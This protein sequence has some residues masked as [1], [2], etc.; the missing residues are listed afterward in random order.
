M[1][2][3]SLGGLFAQAPNQNSVTQN[4]ETVNY[5]I[6]S[7][8][9]VTIGIEKLLKI[10]DDSTFNLLTKALKQNVKQKFLCY[11]KLCH[12]IG[13]NNIFTINCENVVDLE[14]FYSISSDTTSFSNIRKSSITARNGIYFFELP[15][16]VC[17][18]VIK[19]NTSRFVS[20]KLVKADKKSAFVNERNSNLFHSIGTGI[21]LLLLLYHIVLYI[22]VREKF[23][24][25]YIIQLIISVMFI[26]V[27][28]GYYFAYVNHHLRIITNFALYAAIFYFFI[29]ISKFDFLSKRKFPFYKIVLSVYSLISLLN[30]FVPGVFAKLLFDISCLGLIVFFLI[31]FFSVY[32]SARPISFWYYIVA[33][34]VM[35]LGQTVYSLDDFY[36]WSQYEILNHSVEVALLAYNMILSL[37]LGNKINAY[38]REKFQAE[39]AEIEALQEKERLTAEQ[40]ILLEKLIRD[41]NKELL[42]KIRISE[43]QKREIESQNDTINYRIG[44]I[45]KINRELIAKNEEISGQNIELEKHHKKLEQIVEKRNKKLVKARE[46]AII[47]DK[48]KTSFLNNLTQE[49][50]IP[51]NAITGYSSILTDKELSKDSRDEYLHKIIAYVDILLESVENIVILSRLEAD[52]IKSRKTTIALKDVIK[53][54][55]SIFSEK[56][57]TFFKNINFQLHLP[58]I[59]DEL[60]VEIDIEKIRQISIIIANTLVKYSM[61]GELNFKFNFIKAEE[62]DT[63]KKNKL[64]WNIIFCDSSNSNQQLIDLF[65]NF[66]KKGA[67]K[68][69]YNNQIELGLLIAKGYMGIMK[70]K[71][72]IKSLGSECSKIKLVFPI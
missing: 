32:H 49:I 5:K 31:S 57:N 24:L 25:V 44:E 7:E 53:E 33:W 51:M 2:H 63:G 26:V 45:E 55:Q 39:V 6:F 14:V 28:W 52:I 3:L 64:V 23:Y 40:N 34:S 10:K 12:Q 4:Y 29:S 58:V 41:R 17:N 35:F 61:Q 37:A 9:E 72:S 56:L 71:S 27:S 48:L 11:F 70:A 8:D 62:Q 59:E 60:I 38:K 22:I 21:L 43:T 19:V 54:I 69:K 67:K 68:S 16:E 1:I 13:E 36:K 65:E 46:R 42:E 20:F 50:N 15:D 18:A 66:F 47:A 30:I